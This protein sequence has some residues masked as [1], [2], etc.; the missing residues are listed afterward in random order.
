MLQSRNPVWRAGLACIAGEVGELDEARAELKRFADTDF[1]LLR[2][3]VRWLPGLVLLARACSRLGEA[4]CAPPL[5]ERLRPFAGRYVVIGLGA[6]CL[7]PVDHYLGL[8][9]R[10]SGRWEEAERHFATALEL[11]VQL[12]ARPRLA[13]TRV[14]YAAMLLERG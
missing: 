8:L 3:D 12:G 6:A 4:E 9:A 10:T 11:S 13:D 14:A 5:Y 1:A 7:G 2:R